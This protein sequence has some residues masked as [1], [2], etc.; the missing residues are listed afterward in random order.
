MTQRTFVHGALEWGHGIEV[1]LQGK[2]SLVYFDKAGAKPM[3][4]D[5]ALATGT[6]KAITLPPDEVAALALRAAGRKPKASATSAAKKRSAAKTAK[7]AVFASLA[8]QL[9]L[10][11]RLFAGGFGGEAFVKDARGPV[12]AGV[13]LAQELLSS[14]VF[15][16]EANERV[17]ENA[18]QLLAQ[19]NIAHP[20][21]EGSLPFKSIP[22][23]D[24]PAAVAALKELLHGSGEYGERLARFAAALN[25]RDKKGAARKVTWPLA[26]VFGALFDPKNN[27]PVKT[28]AFT[29]QA[30]TLGYELER[31]SNLDAAAYTKFLEVAVKTRDALVTAGQQPRD[32]LDVYTFITRTHAEKPEPAEPGAAPAA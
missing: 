16:G 24:R 25:L 5:T 19:T 14:K 31:S 1:A 23:A 6:L 2:K 12:D 26:T 30:R 9:A 3:Y 13:A 7:K 17:F 22:E 21:F 27:T 8:E 15:S 18:Q 4:V 20:V 11:E 28:T 32:L 10:F 29:S